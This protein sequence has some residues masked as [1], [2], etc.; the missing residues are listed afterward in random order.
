VPSSRR[1]NGNQRLIVSDGSSS[2]RARQARANSP[3]QAPGG[4]VLKKE[5]ID[6]AARNG[7]QGDMKINGLPGVIPSL[8]NYAEFFPGMPKSWALTFMITAQRPS[9]LGRSNKDN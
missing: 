3:R 5:T 4:R 1:R 6:M 2:N 9:S 7:P 8:S